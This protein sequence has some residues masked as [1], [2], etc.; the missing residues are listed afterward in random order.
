MLREVQFY[1]L[2]LSF[3]PKK[4]SDINMRYM[5]GASNKPFDYL[6]QGIGVIVSNLPE[7]E[8]LY[9]DAGYAIS[10]DCDSIDSMV[11]AFSYCLL[12]KEEV[13]MMGEN[14]RTRVKSEWNYEHQFQPVLRK[15]NAV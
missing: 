12:H 10:C 3:M 1:D 11:A 4:S 7:W 8:E 6:S 2:G 5:A 9:V 15:M 13:R 14:G